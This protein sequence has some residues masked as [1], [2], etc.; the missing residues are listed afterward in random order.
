MHLPIAYLVL[1]SSLLAI[2]SAGPLPTTNPTIAMENT[3]MYP[4]PTSGPLVKR[5]DWHGDWMTFRAG[6]CDFLGIECSGLP[7]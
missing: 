5:I 2:A 4:T 3:T 6:L 7:P 1:L